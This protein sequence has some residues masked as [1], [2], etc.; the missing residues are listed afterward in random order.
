M[1]DINELPE[2]KSDLYGPDYKPL[3]LVDAIQKLGN[4][5]LKVACSI[6]KDCQTKC[7]SLQ[8]PKTI[9]QQDAQVLSAYTY[10]FGHKKAEMNPAAILTR[11]LTARTP[12][13]LERIKDFL[14]LIMR[15]VRKLPI[16]EERTMYR[17]LS[18]EIRRG[19]SHYNKDNIV[20]WP[21]MSYTSP[22][23]NSAKASLASKGKKVSG[24]VFIIAN[25]WGYDLQKYS[26][27][28]EKICLIEPER[29][30]GVSSVLPTGSLILVNIEMIDS[31]L[32]LP[33]VFGSGEVYEI[34]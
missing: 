33:E 16:T 21:E 30:F 26:L 15:V 28:G 1:I 2:I 3:P 5:K 7:E 25:G 8:L 9:S 11:E 14:Y 6:V 18:E 19:P 32:L 34:K 10:D 22:D 29:Q 13:G 31:P 27:N 12:E 17:A 23:M 24:T 20:I 4:Y